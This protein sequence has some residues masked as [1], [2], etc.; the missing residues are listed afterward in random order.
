MIRVEG[1][2]FCAFPQSRFAPEGYEG[3][4]AFEDYHDADMPGAEPTILARS[5]ADD[6]GIPPSLVGCRRYESDS[7]EVCFIRRQ[8]ED[9]A[10]IADF[11][12]TFDCHWSLSV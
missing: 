5:L 3:S 10:T 4:I 11:C 2:Q 6:S 7:D 8:R 9:R 12:A 1:N